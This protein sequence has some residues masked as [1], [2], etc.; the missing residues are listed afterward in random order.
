MKNSSFVAGNH[1][2][3]SV[4]KSLGDGWYKSWC[5]M[6][7]MLGC[8]DGQI[9]FRKLKASEEALCQSAYNFLNMMKCLLGQQSV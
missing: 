2:L 3:N 9:D 6:W 5:Y 7:H 8:V 1:D 4:A